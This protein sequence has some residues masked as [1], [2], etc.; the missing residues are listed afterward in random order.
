MLVINNLCKKFGQKILFKNFNLELKGN[1]S[2]CITGSSGCGKSTLL[3]MIMGIE[4]F[5]GG[6]IKKDAKKISAVFQEDRLIEDLSCYRNIAIVKGYTD[7]KDKRMQRENIEK[8]AFELGIGSLL[9]Q[10]SGSLSGG[11]KRR[12]CIA[13]AL[14]HNGDL[15]I[16]DEAFKGLDM[17]LKKNVLLYVKK[18]T[19]DKQC[20]LVSHDED[21]NMIFQ[22]RKI[23][24]ND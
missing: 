21:E 4:T 3:D 17:E 16:F 7:N 12:L 2:I 20:I 18:S 24:L 10:K 1:E 14:Y 19:A 8:I 9:L 5:D 23:S 6:S 11:E 22:F 13:R 15:M